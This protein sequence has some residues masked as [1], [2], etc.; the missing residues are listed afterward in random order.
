[1]MV[2][3]FYVSLDSLLDGAASET[4]RYDTKFGHTMWDEMIENVN[5]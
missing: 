1:M 4:L 2:S 5:Q 3:L